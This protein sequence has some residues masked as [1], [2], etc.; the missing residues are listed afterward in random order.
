MTDRMAD[1]L[2]KTTLPC[3]GPQNCDTTA[4]FLHAVFCNEDRKVVLLTVSALAGLGIQI[5]S[6]ICDTGAYGNMHLL[7]GDTDKETAFIFFVSESSVRS[8]AFRQCMYSAI[9]KDKPVMAVFLE[10]TV[11]SAGMQMEFCGLRCL[12]KYCYGEEEFMRL[13]VSTDIVSYAL[14]CKGEP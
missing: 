11:L 8:R 6:E 12:H 13:L 3:K 4:Y 7:Q 14:S 1:W 10:S 9:S 2:R 5:Q